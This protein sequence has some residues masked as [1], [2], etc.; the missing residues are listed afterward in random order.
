MLNLFLPIPG[1]HCFFTT[2]E[3]WTDTGLE[4]YGAYTHTG[5][6]TNYQKTTDLQERYR[7]EIVR[8][9]G[10]TMVRNEAKRV[11]RD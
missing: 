7:D 3:Y 6:M 10:E 11:R 8:K 4:V 2:C 1:Q 9:R 5:L